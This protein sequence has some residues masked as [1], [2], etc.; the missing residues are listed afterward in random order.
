T[1]DPAYN[2]IVNIRASAFRAAELVG[3]LM[4]FS[5]QQTLQ[6][7]FAHLGEWL[8]ELKPTVKASLGEKIDLKLSSDRD[9]WSVKADRTQIQ[10][11]L[12]NFASN[13]RDAMPSGGSFKLSTRNITERDVR[14][15][16][17]TTLP[18][19]EYVVIEASDDGAGIPADVRQKIFDPFFTTK[20]V[21]KGT[22]LGLAS[23]YGI[24]KQLSGF[25]FCDSE[26]GRGTTFR[27]FLP[28]AHPD[29]ESE[30][31]Q[32]LRGQ[33]KDTKPVDLTGSATVLIVDDDDMVRSVAKRQLVRLGYRVLEAGNGQEALDAIA[34]ENGNVDI[35]ISDVVM[36]EMDGPSFLKAVRPLHPNLKIIFVSGHTNE[37]F[38]ET[39]GGEGT[40]A[41]LQKPFSLPRLA[42]KVKDELGR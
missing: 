31:T 25:I 15:F 9:L 22:G 29:A 11:I 13:S 21:G 17:D 7:E 20:D 16:G 34:A 39:I 24:V 38:R 2:D 18:D 26:V 32:A 28:R 36:P 14:R 33:K 4:S 8:T 42:E 30:R 23:V 10:Q 37:A 1:S 35:V 5:R 40:F 41:F 19:G 6:L 3:Q 12:M 27:I